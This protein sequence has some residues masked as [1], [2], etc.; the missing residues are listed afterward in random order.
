MHVG[1][2]LIFI[3]GLAAGL[4]LA[5][6]YPRARRAPETPVLPEPQPIPLPVE[7]VATDTEPTESPGDRLFRLTREI[8]AQDDRIQ[9][10]QDLAALPQFREGVELLS[11]EAFTAADILKHLGSPGYVL[12]SMAALALAQRSDSAPEPAIAL[13]SQ[14]SGYTLH[15]LLDYLQT[16]PDAAALP[17]LLRHAQPWWWDFQPFRQR[18][19]DYLLWAE[20][21]PPAL[22]LPDLDDLDEPAIDA[23]RE[24]LR[25][26]QSPATAPL[27]GELDAAS[28]RRRERRVLSGFG[29]VTGTTPPHSRILHAGLAEQLEQLREQFDAEPSESVLVSGEYGVGKTVL[30]DL[31]AERLH[32]EGWLVFEATAAEILAGQKYIGELEERVREM[33]SVLNRRRA[34]WRVPDFFDLLSKGAHS[35]DPRGIL[36]L[37]LPAIERGELRLIGEITPRQLAQLLI[38][39]PA[40][41]HHFEILTLRPAEPRALDGIAA[42]W[43]RVQGERHGRTVADARTLSEGARMAAQYFPEQ[44][45]PGRLLRLLNDTLQTA[46]AQEPPA[47]PID[48]DALLSTIAARSGLPLDVI[49]DRQSLDLDALSAFF[50]KRVIGQDEAVDSLLDRIAMLKAGLIDGGRPI[51]VFLFAGPTGTGKTELAK[52]LG[53]LLFGSDERLLRLDMSEYQ[54]EDAAWRLTASE[55]GDSGVRSLTSRIREQ[56]FSVV[57]LDEFEK[58]HPKVWDL[59]LQVFDDARLSDRNGHTVDFRHSIIILTSN[60][61]STISRTA[62]P[63]FTSV[64]GGYSRSAV[65]KA[66]FETFR[67][68]FL[69]RL[70][71]IVLFNPLDR[72]LMREILH[73]ELNRV[74]TR[75][76]LRNRD[77]AVEWEPSA[78]EFLLDRGFTPDLGARPLRRAIEHYLLAPLARRIVE[79]RAP[80]G[81][82]FLFVR[83]AGDKLDV[84]FI[85]PDGPPAATLPDAPPLLGV[86]PADLRD[87]VYTPAATST[88]IARLD[89]RTRELIDDV[90]SPAWVDA[91]DQ[92]F[93]RMAESDFWS[94]PGRFEVLDRIERRDRIESA[95]DTAER[96]RNRLRQDG[97]NDEFVG[98]LAQ[99]LFLLGLAVD[100]LREGRPQDALLEISASEAD[101]KRDGAELRAWWQQLLGMYLAWVERRN[102]RVEVLRQDAEQCRAWLAVGGFGAHELLDTENGL[103]VR[104][105]EQDGQATRRVSLQVRVVADLPGRPRHLRDG[106]GEERRICRRYRDTPSPLVRD[107]VRG[108]RSGRLDRVLGGEFDVMQGG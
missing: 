37:I 17:H 24:T 73:K 41:K 32:G 59:F 2:L 55:G 92:D 105:Q 52:A 70:D 81:D 68:E 39:R 96:L 82:Q 74:L 9:R 16:R 36:D 94:S 54:S 107:T 42:E 58:A 67:R 80:Q 25:R 63:G 13:A 15:F 49:D 56:P 61:G 106:Q 53:E 76:G 85:D 108:W 51:G 1:F 79:H 6:A 57:L 7:P 50:R 45:E 11:G 46:T 88:A 101:R 20:Q 62:G 4:L 23:L 12:P 77:W 86:T 100:A 103:H 3:V 21:Y 78:I 40:V 18:L 64:S 31:L 29:R 102:M 89:A 48:V 30:I 19:R 44:H 60:V 47:L 95:L 87:L 97:G 38:A 75:R 43:A 26:F 8:D 91:R 14:L 93:A 72:G 104:E 71:R 35:Q 84:Q 66:L 98:R 69:N 83:S 65:E 28:Q 27:L 22:D 5:R 33:L 99:L 90:A 34:L 10:P